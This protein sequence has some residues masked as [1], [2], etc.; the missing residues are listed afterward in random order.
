MTLLPHGF[1]V[2][3]PLVADWAHATTD[4]RIQTRGPRSFAEIRAFYDQMVPHAKSALDHLEEFDIDNL[5]EP[6]L[7]LMQLVLALAHAT[8]AVEV[9]RAAHV[10]GV[11][12]P[13]DIRVLQGLVP[14][15]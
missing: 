9:Q 15:G 4:E 10:P 14:F 8:I 2:L 1:E 3:E 6:Q 5:P 13:H 7:A 12:Y 11:R